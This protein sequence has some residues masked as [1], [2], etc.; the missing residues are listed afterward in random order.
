MTGRPEEIVQKDKFL[1]PF[2]Q[3]TWILFFL[4]G[5]GQ[6]KGTQG[7]NK[8]LE[9]FKEKQTIVLITPS[10][11]DSIAM[12]S[13]TARSSDPVA[14]LPELAVCINVLMN[15]EKYFR[16]STHAA[17]SDSMQFSLSQRS[18]S[19]AFLVPITPP[20]K[21]KLECRKQLLFLMENSLEITKWLSCP[22]KPISF[23]LE[24]RHI[25]P[26]LCANSDFQMTLKHPK[27]KG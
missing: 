15:W 25:H 23:L 20:P 24:V 22:Q 4:S 17:S 8:H 27:L 1:A 16:V 5:S 11:L 6:A 26:W 21:T 13:V 18:P 7:F 3:M 2:P 9:N 19:Y 12:F 14:S 10:F